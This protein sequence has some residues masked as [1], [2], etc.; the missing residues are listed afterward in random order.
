MRR[1]LLS[2]L[3]LLFILAAPSVASAVEVSVDFLPLENRGPDEPFVRIYDATGATNHITISTEGGIVVVRADPAPVPGSGCVAEDAG[4]VRCGA[5]G[6]AR[7]AVS[8]SGGDDRVAVG[9]LAGGTFVRSLEI[10]AGAGDDAV[11]SAG[12]IPVTWHGGPGSDT[13][14]GDLITSSY[15][16]RTAPVAVSFDGVANDGEPG[17]GDDVG[18]VGDALGGSGDDELAAG[19]VGVGLAGGPGDDRLTG[20]PGADT[21]DGGF[22]EDL[23]VGL[24]GDDALRDGGG[25]DVLLG[26]EGNDRL[27]AYVDA[28]SEDQLDGGPGVDRATVTT[29]E[30]PFDLGL[31]TGAGFGSYRDLE[32]IELTTYGA[33]RL[34]GSAAGEKL[35]L[36]GRAGSRLDGGGGDDVLDSGEPGFDGIRVSGGAGRDVVR[37]EHLDDVLALRDRERDRVH[38]PAGLLTVPEVDRIDVLS[39]CGAPV[40]VSEGRV[41]LARRRVSA[42][43]R[44]PA[45]GRE[46]CRGRLIL[47]A[48]VDGPE[49]VRIARLARSFALPPATELRLAIALGPRTA[50]ALRRARGYTTKVDARTV[51]V[52]RG[53]DGPVTVRR[54]LDLRRVGG[55]A[56]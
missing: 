11:E 23:V 19:P 31:Q 43:V 49:P 7:I 45:V 22:D 30:G 46:P 42:A 8:L 44:C 33:A 35:T 54:T 18:T 21:L 25:H 5:Y 29:G 2:G 4:V 48:G 10:Y 20:G 41:D 36:R 28:S 40:D 37:A 55:R 24:G 12:M 6:P 26:G 3:V 13:T 34:R 39:G 1:L 17:E 15:R 38:C 14:H 27:S 50:A 52:L 47:R 9:A 16:E 51:R 32:Q 56:R 53:Q